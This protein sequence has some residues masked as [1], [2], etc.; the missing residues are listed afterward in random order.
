MVLSI[1]IPVDNES[2]A[3]PAFLSIASVLS[4]S[5]QATNW[6]SWTTE[7]GMAASSSLGMRRTIPGSRS[8]CSPEFRSP[9]GDHGGSGFCVRAT[10]SW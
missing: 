3:I 4:E 5:K 2:D 6:F 1:V 8:C 7:A 9:G 10:P